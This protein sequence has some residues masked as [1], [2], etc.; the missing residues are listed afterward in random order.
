M[1]VN[2]SHDATAVARV[3]VVADWAVDPDE[4]VA[5]CRRRAAEGDVAFALVVPAWL[6]GLDWVGD[7]YASRPCAAR[8]LEA[9]TRMASDAGLD[10]ELAEVG[11][12][13]PTSAIEDARAAYPATEI[14]V[15]GRRR[16]VTHP[17]A[18]VDRVRRASGLT[19]RE[20]AIPA[21][22]S[23]R[24]RRGWRVLREGGHCEGR[25]PAAPSLT[26]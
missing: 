15:C 18:L 17:F 7:P 25:I 14:L 6:H 2:A 24:E 19:V 12:P 21:V 1:D 9:L 23:E 13:D 4:V 10:V 20:A 16:R 8:Q 11:D 3:L 5:A 22:P 26:R